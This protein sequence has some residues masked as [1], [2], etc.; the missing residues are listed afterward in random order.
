MIRTTNTPTSVG[1]MAFKTNDAAGVFYNKLI[2][3]DNVYI[4]NGHLGSSTIRVPKIW[5]HD[6][7]CDGT[8]CGAGASGWT[9][10]S[11]NGR[12]YPTVATD[13]VRVTNKLQFQDNTVSDTKFVW[14]MHAEI[15]IPA[16]GTV[17]FVMRDNAGTTVQEW[18]RT[19]LG[20]QTNSN[21]SR[22]DMS[23]EPMTSVARKLGRRPACG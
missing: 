13:D 14:D 19:F 17:K 2:I 9:R 4:D 11:T 16:I 7:D 15:P 21:V 22:L 20:S 8:G 12:L 1:T 6:F 18:E 5:V 10:D 3:N 23:F